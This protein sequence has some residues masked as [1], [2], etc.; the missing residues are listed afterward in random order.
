MKIK[1][2]KHY[3]SNSFKCWIVLTRD[4]FKLIENK[5]DKFNFMTAFSKYTPH[6]VKWV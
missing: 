3:E 2:N 1:I 6:L 5:N 4:T